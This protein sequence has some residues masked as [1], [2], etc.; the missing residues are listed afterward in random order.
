[1]RLRLFTLGAA[2]VLA[3]ISLSACADE[4]VL[5]VKDGAAP[6]RQVAFTMQE[7]EALP[8]V[9]FQTT[10][11]W[12]DGVQRFSGPALKT[13]LESAGFQG[14][15]VKARAL[16]DYVVEIPAD[17]LRGDAPIIA[18]RIQGAHFP[19]REKGPL[20]I[21]YPFDSAAAYQTELAYA[22]SIWQLNRIEV[23]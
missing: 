7:L 16:N 10:T 11:V 19:R 15:T 21:V 17:T 14:E 20:W 3:L 23:Q 9:E 2:A 22:R 12:T 13:V 6:G 18:T 4:T 5:T 1:M 8:Q